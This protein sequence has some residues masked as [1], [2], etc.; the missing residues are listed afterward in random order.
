LHR[1]IAGEHVT[2]LKELVVAEFIDHRSQF[3][4]IAAA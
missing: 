4:T 3:L 2:D 1:S